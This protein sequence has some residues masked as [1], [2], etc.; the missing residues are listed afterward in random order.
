M[1]ILLD[2]NFLMMPGQFKVDIYQLLKGKELCTLD[3]CVGELEELSKGKGKSASA[4][5]IALG[6]LRKNNIK[7]I[8]AEGKADDAIVA[9]AKG[10]NYI[11]G[12]NDAALMES[13]KR[14][15]VKILRLKQKKFLSEE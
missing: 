5:K 1:K 10:G 11:V 8:N 7:I 4:A 15:G 14:Y 13:L 2:T 12:T 6:L 9:A 3:V